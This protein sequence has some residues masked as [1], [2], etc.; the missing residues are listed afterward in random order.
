M[1]SPGAGA[2]SPAAS[3]PDRS[4]IASPST[5]SASYAEWNGPN[6]SGEADTS[7]PGPACKSRKFPSEAALLQHL[8]TSPAHIQCCGR[9]FRL[10]THYMQHRDTNP[11]HQP[12]C[13]LCDQ[14]FRS[15]R[16]LDA[17]FQSSSNH[18]NCDRCS[19]GFEHE[20]ILRVHMIC[21][22][23]TVICSQCPTVGPIYPEDLPDHYMQVD[24]HPK[25]EVCHLGFEDEILY[26]QLS[27]HGTSTD[28]GVIVSE[29]VIPSCSDTI[30]EHVWQAPTSQDLFLSYLAFKEETKKAEPTP[31]TI[32]LD[33]SPWT[34][35]PA[36]TAQQ[37]APITQTVPEAT[38]EL[39]IPGFEGKIFK[40]ADVL[41]ALK[42]LQ[43]YDNGSS[44]AEDSPRPASAV[45]D[46]D[47][48][49]S[50]GAEDRC[51]DPGPTPKHADY[52]MEEV[53][54]DPHYNPW[55]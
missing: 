21:S 22:H 37:D 41:N 1:H 8:K 15:F 31:D 14:D 42:A 25:C 13:V 40:L 11:D 33:G 27:Q 48:R 52:R 2:A 35:N 55:G 38:I 10:E 5:S 43:P 39:P 30:K 6:G 3:Q 18:P 20:K 16:E 29:T 49:A 50:A 53:V 46:S 7:C 47:A 44:T 28:E 26:E 23:P 54:A 19:K 24:K 9:G 45:V 51:E 32:A 12:R 36:N 4:I 34:E 17:H